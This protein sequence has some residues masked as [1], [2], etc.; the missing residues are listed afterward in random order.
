MDWSLVLASQGI[1]AIIE[2][3]PPPDGWVLLIDPREYPRSIAAL[4]QY[5][6][7]NRRWRWRQDLSWSG[8]TFHWG[9]LVWC[10]ILI[11]FHWVAEA[12]GSRLESAGIMDS[13]A[14]RHGDWWRLFTAVSL[15][16]D[17]GHLAANVSTGFLVLGLAM[18]RYGPGCALLAVFMAGAAGNLAGLAVRQTPYYGLGASGMVMGGLGLLAVQ[19]IP[20]A[21]SGPLGFR[22]FLAGL[23]AGV[24][25]FIL[26]GLNPAS[27]V[28]AHLAGFVSGVLMGAAL[29]WLPARVVESKWTNP[30][31]A[32]LVAALAIATWVLALR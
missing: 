15:H 27:D 9:A 31:A 16:G 5:H 29:A 23:F 2:Y 18:A 3:F 32:G 11:G 26:M 1:E 20:L 28:L 24:C 8:L 10:A 19:S 30:T 13:A 25:L 14:F 21:R 22:R 4:R 12:F 6:L 17:V 7:E